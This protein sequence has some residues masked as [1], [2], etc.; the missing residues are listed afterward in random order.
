MKHLL[1]IFKVF[2]SKDGS[3]TE[4]LLLVF[5]V[6][7]FI[8]FGRILTITLSFVYLHH[9]WTIL[10][11][12]NFRFEGRLNL[13][14]LQ[15]FPINSPE[16]GMGLDFIFSF[17]QTSQ[18]LSGIFNQQLKIKVNVKNV[19]WS[20]WILAPLY[21]YLWPLYWWLLD[22]RRC[23]LLWRRIIPPRP[24]HQREVG[25]QA[26]RTAKLRMPTNRR[27]C[28]MADSV[29]SATIKLETSSICQWGKLQSQIF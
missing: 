13:S 29:L 3:T 28:H 15:L 18:P 16:E 19:Q 8:T 10:F 6:M 26:F 21:R 22:R 27:S 11:T 14:R 4:T 9:V 17:L 1:S 12:H 25:P 2:R 7:L 5:P 24:R 20:D 23:D